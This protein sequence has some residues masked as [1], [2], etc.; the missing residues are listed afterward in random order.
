VLL[1]E[2]LA[3]A[4]LREKPERRP[5]RLSVRPEREKLPTER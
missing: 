2:R 5:E 3:S 1:P 4:P